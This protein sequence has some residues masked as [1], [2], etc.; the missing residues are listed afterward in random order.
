MYTFTTFMG[1]PEVQNQ[2]TKSAVEEYKRINAGENSHEQK[3]YPYIKTFV[4]IPI[5]P[6]LILS[7]H[8]FQLDGLYGWGGWDIHVWYICGSKF[9]F[10]LTLWIS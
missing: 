7:Y 9:I 6:F 1:I 10:K 2:H 4:S 3:S 8:E 5:L